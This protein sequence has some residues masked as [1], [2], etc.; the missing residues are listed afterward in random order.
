M[1]SCVNIPLINV[2]FFPYTFVNTLLQHNV[3]WCMSKHIFFFFL[4][5]L[6]YIITFLLEKTPFC[7]GL[8]IKYFKIQKLRIF[9]VF[10]LLVSDLRKNKKMTRN[11]QHF[12]KLHQFTSHS[13]LSL[14]RAHNIQRECLKAVS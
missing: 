13:S 5:I 8:L 10:L 2:N 11:F 6:D 14:C 12:V 3:C 9:S 1:V 7:E 4:N